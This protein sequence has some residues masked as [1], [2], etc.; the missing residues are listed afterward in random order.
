MTFHVTIDCP[1]LSRRY[2]RLPVEAASASTAIVKGAERALRDAAGRGMS[3]DLAR[4]SRRKALS[5]I[6]KY[7]TVAE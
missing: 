7:A 3:V 2:E 1:Q 5:T 4:L 6:G